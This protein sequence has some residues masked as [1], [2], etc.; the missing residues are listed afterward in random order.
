MSII[1][2]VWMGGLES[3]PPP[4]FSFSVSLLKS[5]VRLG[6]KCLSIVL[7]SVLESAFSKAS[8]TLGSG[9][10]FSG[11]GR[12]KRKWRGRERGKEGRKGGREGDGARASYEIPCWICF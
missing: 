8:I 7:L 11:L 4:P 5:I 1:T 6:G 12:G 10:E 9:V 2:I 3:T